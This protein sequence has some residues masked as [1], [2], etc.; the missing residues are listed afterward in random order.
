MIKAIIFTLATVVIVAA[1]GQAVNCI[2]S[3]TVGR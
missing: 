3:T 1:P 2:A